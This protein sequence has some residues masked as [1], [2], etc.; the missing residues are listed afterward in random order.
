VVSKP[1]LLG[2][3]PAL[4]GTKFVAGTMIAKDHANDNSF[5]L[6]TKQKRLKLVMTPSFTMR[7]DNSLTIIAKNIPTV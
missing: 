6:Q 7:D 1:K 5:H 2:I 3:F 4:L